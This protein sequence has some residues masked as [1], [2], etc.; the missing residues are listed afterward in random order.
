MKKIAT[1]NK[2][3]AEAVRQVERLEALAKEITPA[4]LAEHANQAHL[5][6][7]VGPRANGSGGDK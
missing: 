4:K 6:P 2:A 7:V 5:F 3:V 1:G